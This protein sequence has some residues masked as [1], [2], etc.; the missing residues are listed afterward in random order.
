MTALKP[1]MRILLSILT[2][3]LLSGHGFANDLLKQAEGNWKGKGWFKN[4]LD[5][6]KE[7]AR[8]RYKNKFNAK[9][10]T[11][12]IIGKCSTSSRTFNTSGNIAVSKKQGRFSGSW[13]NPRGIGT[14]SLAGQQSGSRIL[15]TFR[16][17]EQTTSKRLDHRSSWKISKSNLSLVGSVK[18]PDTGKFSKLS[19]MEFSR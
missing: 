13:R 14:I 8:C 12:T 6:P 7:T 2:I 9:N 18:N 16:A 3:S 4:G 11:L 5:A 17:K 19:V 15:F 10:D 1:M